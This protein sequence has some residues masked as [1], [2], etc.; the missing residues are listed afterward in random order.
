MDL[1]DLVKACESS[2]SSPT[3]LVTLLAFIEDRLVLNSPVSPLLVKALAD[4]AR[5]QLGREKILDS[6]LVQD[7][8]SAPWS[9][10]SDLVVEL[11]RLGGNLCYDCPLGRETVTQAGLLGKLSS[12]I[13][14]IELVGQSKVWTVL[15][16]FLHNF[17]AENLQ[18]LNT[19]QQL[20]EVTAKH[21]ALNDEPMDSSNTLEEPT[22]VT[23]VNESALES[24]ASFLAG[25]TDHEGKNH[26]FSL[27]PLVKSIIYILQ[28][29]TSEETLNTVLELLQ[30]LGEDETV[31]NVY[32]KNELVT[33][34]LLKV[35]IW[36]TD[37]VTS[38]LDLLALLSSYSSILPK[39]LNPTSPLHTAVTAW[40]INQP[41]IHHT[42]TA[43]L[44]YGNF[45]TTDASCLQ[46]LSTTIP[47]V[48][49][50]LLSPSS[51][52]KLLH[53]VIGCLRNLSVC[54]AAREQLL[55]LFLP[56]ASCQLLLH[57]STGSDH[58][59]TP[60]LLS[61]VRLVT[62]GDQSSCTRIGRDLS[63]VQG[64]VKIGQH[65]LVPALNIEATRLLSSVIRYS[66][67]ITVVENTISADVT[68]LLLG[69]LNSPHPQLLNE[70]LV[71]LNIGAANRPPNAK[72]VEQ[73]D[74]EF[75]ASKI[76]DIIKMENCPKEIKSNSVTL[77]HNIIEWKMSGINDNFKNSNLKETIENF[78]SESELSKNIIKL[79][80]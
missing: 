80:C 56:E 2:P 71:A 6:N 64:I 65:S 78:D 4:T 50:T 43:A 11:C 54:Q 34:L 25:L 62:Q 48:L 77:V 19:V 52:H 57:L 59:V 74:S 16:A 41:S 75:L 72:L 32:V 1:S 30:D 21:F 63:L 49:V 13:P 38:T 73:I 36:P 76:V 24:Y 37:L 61:T 3:P 67:D 44:I 27:L 23:N 10:D 47:P 28:V 35:N 14:N 12:I 31:S 26:L 17:C 42:A 68:P 45:C 51:P 15:P 8:C 70:M 22:E 5:N 46:L 39:I 7:I 69:L 40:F 79:L 53:A 60:K 66:K 58:T 29:S 33:F 55:G 20:A 9:P 18:C